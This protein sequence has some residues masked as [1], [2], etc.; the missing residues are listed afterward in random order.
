MLAWGQL[1]DPVLS[2]VGA[3]PLAVV[4]LARTIRRRAWRGPD[5]ALALAGAASVPVAYGAV[6]LIGRLGGYR[7]QAVPTDLVS[8]RQLGSQLRTAAESVTVLFGCHFPELHGWFERTLGGLH[9]LGL[10][11]VVVAVARTVLLAW[12]GIGDRVDQVIVAGIA[13]STWPPSSGRR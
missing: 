6:W 4:C 5:A 8:W 10:G 7:T 1:A 3:V 12:R 11:L 9:L 2:L 13:D